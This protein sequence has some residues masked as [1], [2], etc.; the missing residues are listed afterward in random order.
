VERI[1]YQCQKSTKAAW[2]LVCLPK[3][4]GGLRVLNLQT[5]NDA[6][7]LKKLHKFFNRMDIP[8]VHLVWESYYSDESL[9]SNQRKGSFWWRDNLKLLDSFKGLARV[10][11]CDGASCLFWEDLW[12]DHV[13]KLHFPE[14]FSFAK[15]TGISLKT[16]KDATGPTALLHLPI[17][18]IALQQLNELAQLLVNLPNSDEPDCRTYIWGTAFYSASKAY[19]HLIGHR[20]LHPAFRWMWKLACQNKHKV[21]FFVS[22]TRQ[23]KY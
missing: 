13:P 5:Q 20:N 3:K 9:P 7:L 2:E 23:I 21:F 4:E 17:S 14:L 18:Q 6:L 8:W 11:V 16:A 22:T 10:N 12:G 15:D 1:R 19:V